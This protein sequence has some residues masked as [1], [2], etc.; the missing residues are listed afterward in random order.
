MSGLVVP[1]RRR[2][3][4]VTHHAILRFIKRWRP[5]TGFAEA[6]RQMRELAAR[7]VPT[8][9]RSIRRDAWIYTAL[10]QVG[11]H[12][13]LLV[14]DDAVITVLDGTWAEAHYPL[15]EEQAMA[16]EALEEGRLCR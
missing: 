8:R 11:E 7:A 16:F 9:R 1:P 3:L 5:G 10:S 6:R 15:P 14:R 13:E 4:G 2:C 12:I